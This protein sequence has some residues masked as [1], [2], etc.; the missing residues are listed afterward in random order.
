VL[1]DLVQ[2]GLNLTDHTVDLERPGVQARAH[3]LDLVEVE[4]AR[5]HPAYEDLARDLVNGA[6]DQAQRQGAHHQQLNL[7]FFVL[8]KLKMF[9]FFFFCEKKK[10]PLG[11]K[12]SKLIKIHQTA[13]FV[14]E[15]Q[16]TERIFFFF[17]ISKKKF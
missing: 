13:N 17:K 16:K 15:K 8:F 12:I 6:L 11:E 9:S 7:F 2:V 4:D 10:K 3:H 14:M 5:L 1:E